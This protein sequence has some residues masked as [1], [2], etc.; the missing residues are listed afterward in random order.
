VADDRAVPT[1]TEHDD[2]TVLARRL[3]VYYSA[4]TKRQAQRAKQARAVAV[5]SRARRM[6]LSQVQQHQTHHPMDNDASSSGPLVSDAYRVSVGRGLASP[7]PPPLDDPSAP[8]ESCP[9]RL[10]ECEWRADQRARVVVDH[11][12]NGETALEGLAT[13]NPLEAPPI[14]TDT[15][16]PRQRTT[17]V[18]LFL[19]RR[20]LTN[21]Y[22]ESTVRYYCP[23]C[24]QCFLSRPGI[25]YHCNGGSGGSCRRK[26]QQSIQS[27]Q[28]DLALIEQQ[29]CQLATSFAATVA[30]RR[31]VSLI[32]NA[33]HGADGTA[34]VAISPTAVGAAVV[35]RRT[36]PRVIWVDPNDETKTSLSKAAAATSD[37]TRMDPAILNEN[38]SVAVKGDDAMDVETIETGG[39]TLRTAQ[40]DNDEPL[41]SPNDVLAQLEWELYRVQGQMIGPMYPQV[42]KA[43]GYLKPRKVKPP[44]TRVVAPTIPAAAKAVPDTRQD[45]RSATAK[46]APIVKVSGFGAAQSLPL[47]MPKRSNMDSLVPPQPVV[48][49]M[50]PLAMPTESKATIV[51]VRTLVQEV[52]AGRYPTIQ[53]FDGKHDG[54]CAICKLDF[55]PKLPTTPLLSFVAPSPMEWPLNHV[56]PC[57]FCTRSVHLACIHGKYIV[58]EPEPVE[59]FMCH[60]CISVILARRN[61]AEKRRQEKYGDAPSSAT[62]A[63]STATA[64]TPADSTHEDAMDAVDLCK[65]VVADREFECVAAQARRIGD[66]TELLR[67]S[68][69]RLA[70]GLATQAMNQA[71]CARLESS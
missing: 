15:T 23:Q 26:I 31:A 67:D 30:Q 17:T 44:R 43:L 39:P 2:E 32:S 35:P 22:N 58:K 1:A 27:R 34:A 48:E 4:C 33:A 38:S 13:N 49:R 19:Q 71:R 36:G 5:T 69:S 28:R 53:R 57:N 16:T 25:K 51:D 8:P 61:R 66:L 20:L 29:A 50:A 70:I 46:A 11:Q 14:V 56:F 10:V 63:T 24:W 45:A 37:R 6:L 68:Q 21:A 54:Y 9:N 55:P 52:D 41:V 62:D 3:K 42:F 40:A 12:G 60:H 18:R 7:P 65:G 59:D 47:S 64:V